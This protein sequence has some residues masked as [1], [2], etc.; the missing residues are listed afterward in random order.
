MRT[1]APAPGATGAPFLAVAA[2]RPFPDGASAAEPVP[3]GGPRPSGAGN[4]AISTVTPAPLAPATPGSSAAGAPQLRSW[5]CAGRR[6]SDGG[7]AR[8]PRCRGPPGGARPRLP[9][10]CWG[11]Q[12][13]RRYRRPSPFPH[14]AQ[15]GGRPASGPD[16]GAPDPGGRSDPPASVIRGRVAGG[17]GGSRRSAPVCPGRFRRRRSILTWGGLARRGRTRFWAGTEPPVRRMRLFLLRTQRGQMVATLSPAVTIF[18]SWCGAVPWVR[19]PAREGPGVRYDWPITV[20]SPVR[21]H[22]PAS[23]ARDGRGAAGGDELDVVI[24]PAGLDHI[25]ALWECLRARA[26]NLEAFTARA[27]GKIASGGDCLLIALVGGAVVGYA[28]A[29]D[30]GPHLRDGYRTARFH[31]LFVVEPLRRHGIG[32]RKIL[33]SQAVGEAGSGSSIGD[34]TRAA[35]AGRG[36]AP[37][38]SPGGRWDRASDPVGSAL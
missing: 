27:R 25:P 13:P 30:Y 32:N 19:C 6:S 35:R 10:A 22:A 17:R 23:V 18:P 2:A 16:P 20:L 28:W 15:P 33:N 4:G 12:P 1:P 9:S 8:C 29:Q 37:H 11:C 24:R 31:D 5:A 38:R 26:D 3:R 14:S 7:R 36:Q 21:T 34:G